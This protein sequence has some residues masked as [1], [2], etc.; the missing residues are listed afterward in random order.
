MP[1]TTG[2]V[3]RNLQSG[4]PWPSARGTCGG[5]RYTRGPAIAY[6]YAEHVRSLTNNSD[7]SLGTWVT[8]WHRESVFVKRSQTPETCD[9][10]TQNPWSPDTRAKA[11]SKA[12]V[13]RRTHAS[14]VTPY[15]EGQAAAARAR[16][17]N[18]PTGPQHRLVVMSCACV[19][20]MCLSSE[21]MEVTSVPARRDSPSA[22]PPRIAATGPR[23]AGRSRCRSG[24]SSGRRWAAP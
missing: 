10:E 19:H 4:S 8:I 5:L 11:L 3:F 22:F 1:C 6:K 21:H 16:P 2:R 24:S 12:S 14:C 20:R 9:G 18:S 17:K 15:T 23:P 7:S 13:A